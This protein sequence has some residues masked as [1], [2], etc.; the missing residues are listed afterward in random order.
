MG[1]DDYV[2]AET[3]LLTAATAAAV[4]PRAREL[5]RRGAV[6]GLAGAM[7]AG[8]VVAAAARGAVRGARESVAQ[9]NGA[10]AG[11]GSGSGG[12]RRASSAR[13]KPVGF[14]SLE[15]AQHSLELGHYSLERP[16]SLGRQPEPIHRQPESRRASVLGLNR[17]DLSAYPVVRLRRPD[18]P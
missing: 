8:D 18:A 4:S 5:L 1:I 16:D 6:Y 12:R 3:G 14:R 15:F 2:N 9:E 11:T 10:A 17:A 7:R 13:G